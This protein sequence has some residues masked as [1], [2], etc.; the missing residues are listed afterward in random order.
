MKLQQLSKIEFEQRVSLI[1][2]IALDYFSKNEFRC[3]QKPVKVNGWPL[4]YARTFK[5]VSVKRRKDAR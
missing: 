4:G 3:Y 2:A 1:K 5:V